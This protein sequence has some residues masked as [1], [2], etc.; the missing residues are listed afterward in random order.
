MTLDEKMLF[1]H[2]NKE[3]LKYDGP[4][5]IPRLGIPSYVIAHG[6]YGTRAHRWDEE[7]GRRFIIP[8]TFMSVSIN[9]A[10]SWDPEL[11]YKV[12]SGVG[13]EIRSA[14]NHA[15][16][17]PAFNI[18]RDLRCGRSP[19]YFTEDPYLNAGTSVPF[20]K[21]LQAQ[22]VMVH[23]KHMVCNNQEFNRGSIDVQVSKRALHEIYF[24]GFEFAVT[25][26]KAMGIMSSY[27]KINGL[28]AAEN[29]YVLTETLRDRWGFNGFVLSDWSGTHSTVPSVKAGLDLEMPRERW[30]GEKLKQAVLAGEVSMELIDKRVS[31]ILRVMHIAKLFDENHENPSYEEVF[32]S[33]RMKG[34][35]QEL[36]LN[37]IAL[38][39]NQN[40]VLP[41]NKN[42]VKKIAVIGPHADYGIHFNEG[43]YDY[44]LYQVGGS[45]N[46]KP[47]SADM[48]TPYI[49][50]KHYLGE[51]VEVLFSPGVYA[52]NGCGPIDPEY[53]ISKDGRQG[54]SATY[55]KNNNFTSAERK[56]VDPT[57]SFQWTQD[58]LVPEEGRP[59]GSANKFS[60]RWEGKIKAPESRSYIFELRFEGNARL[61]IDGEQVFEGNG[62]NN[63]W[64]HQVVTSLSAGEHD[65]KL[66][67]RKTGSKAK[68][69]LWWDVQNI[70][71]TKEAVKMAKSA[72][73]VVINV[74]NSGNMER[75]G[76]DRF[77]G[78]EL[79]LSQQNLI[80]EVAKVNDNL[81][82]VT[83]TS[84][85]TMKN[86]V[87]NVPAI[88]SAFYPGEQAGNA[89]AKILF[90]DANPNGKLPVTLPKSVDQYPENNWPGNVP[91]IEY[92]EG[93]FMGYR[94]FEKNGIEPQFPFG[95]GLSYTTFEYG[96]P[97]V[98][99]KNGKVV[100]SL[101][102]K[103]TGKVEGAEVVQLYVKDVVASV[104]RPVKELKGYKKVNI[105]PGKSEKVSIELE[106]RAFA[107]FDEASDDW[108]V[109]AGDFEFL[110]GSSSADI[111]QTATYTLK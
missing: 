45:A 60:V 5:P 39:K 99:E 17:G 19:E 32:K 51:D 7:A 41:F 97:S 73:V 90:G 10:S 44:T 98:S 82:V 14:N 23:L 43:H 29:P 84:G 46:V 66:E 15:V 83:F 102:V 6:P 104:D 28:W 81:V 89:L 100:V 68:M 87:D 18:I 91:S 74:G 53:L 93:V 106:E 4:P 107:Y 85:I 9:Y 34:L 76:R 70:E 27:N 58:P 77:Q 57:V 50:M 47:D 92:K 88:V 101:N 38:L 22:D 109:E 59:V 62:N 30:Y 110:I 96:K 108:K 31:N 12:G 8:G 25:E 86:W 21:A 13:E 94:W 61:F 1:M 36:A 56:A 105:E 63:Y 16:A 11:V 20:V 54:L 75:E 37:S 111:R 48:I 40:N 55:Y 3:G 80:N 65:L 35:A 64:W 24:P 78:L 26:A 67:Y 71:W 49:G 72:D 2:G 42:E 69:Q 52:E 103:N 95:H 79:S 33:D